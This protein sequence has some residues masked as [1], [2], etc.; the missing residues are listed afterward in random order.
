MIGQAQDELTSLQGNLG[1]VQSQ[2]QQVSTTQQAA[3]SATTQQ[4]ATMEQADPATVATQLSTLQTQL[5]ASYEVTAQ[6]SQLSL[7]HYLPALTG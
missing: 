3:Y 4:I 1:T 6:I 7:V 5:E 2:L